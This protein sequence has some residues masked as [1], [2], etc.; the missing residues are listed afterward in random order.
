MSEEIPWKR[1][2]VE[3]FVIVASILLA[4]GI[5]AWWD[6]RQERQF[7]QEALVGLQEEYRG[8][9]D[10]S[11]RHKSLHDEMVRAVL[12]L[13]KACERG[14]Y[15]SDE[16]PLDRALFLSR[17]PP[18]IDLGDGVA[19]SLISSGRIEILSNR[20][21]RHKITEWNSVLDE[22]VDGQLSSGL[23]IRELMYPYLTRNGIPLMSF[24]SP[25][26]STPNLPGGRSL[27]A[28]SEAMQRLFSDPEYL[29]ILEGRYGA[30]V[31]TSGE[32]VRLIAAIDSI[33]ETI[34]ASLA[35]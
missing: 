7:E 9:L 3:G 16:I 30:L 32:L 22:L 20:M 26:G 2:A 18:T 4:F 31:H 11:A 25:L 15:E 27:A 13:M 28:D 35:N 6:E 19:A 8:H 34:E 33:L 10:T 21:L 12:T 29:S 14:Y 5:D 1:F 17:L 23:Y 24:T